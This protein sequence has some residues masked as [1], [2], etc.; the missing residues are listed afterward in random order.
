M[1]LLLR[2][3]K[4]SFSCGW[5]LDH[6]MM[7]CFGYRLGYSFF[8]GHFGTFFIIRSII[9]AIKIFFHLLRLVDIAVVPVAQHD[10][11]NR[12]LYHPYEDRIVAV[13]PSIVVN[14]FTAV[15]INIHSPAITIIANAW[16]FITIR[17]ISF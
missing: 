4:L 16:L 12:I 3:G 5:F 15:W 10:D 17:R 6:M 13:P 2:Q 1:F 8:L 9:A 7:S 11:R 14:Y